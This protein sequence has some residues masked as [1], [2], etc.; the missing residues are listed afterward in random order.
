M[1][2]VSTTVSTGDIVTINGK[3]AIIGK[4]RRI[5]GKMMIEVHFKITEISCY[6]EFYST[7]KLNQALSTNK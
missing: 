1:K 6:T 5:D 2:T 3:E 4:Q 7:R